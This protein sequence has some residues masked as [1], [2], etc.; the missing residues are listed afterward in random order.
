M[1]SN[2]FPADLKN[3]DKLINIF[4]STYSNQLKFEDFLGLVLARDNSE[5]RFSAAVQR[6]IYDVGQDERLAEQLEFL[7]A[8]YFFK[9]AEYL[10]VM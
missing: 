8:R 9:A 6:E 1:R 2:G 7:L 10:K 4:D 5:V 3:L